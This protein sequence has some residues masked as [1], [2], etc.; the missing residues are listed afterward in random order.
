[1]KQGFSGISVVPGC[2]HGGSNERGR[3]RGWGHSWAEPLAA[4][5]DGMSGLRF[6]CR[7]AENGEDERDSP[8]PQ[9]SDHSPAGSIVTTRR[10]HL[11]HL[12]SL[13]LSAETK[14]SRISHGAWRFLQTDTN[15]EVQFV[16]DDRIDRFTAPRVNCKPR[17][18]CL[19][20]SCALTVILC[21]I[22]AGVA[23]ELRVAGIPQLVGEQNICRDL[24]QVARLIGTA[25]T[26]SSS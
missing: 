7:Q 12:A 21:G 8:N 19:S 4:V 23:N 2:S 11:V 14:D 15:K 9:D 24:R 5:V 10:P 6:G 25:P 1:V 18:M 13:A 16:Y 17:T 26:R 20:R 3:I 22:H